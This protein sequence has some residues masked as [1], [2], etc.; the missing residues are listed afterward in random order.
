MK[1]NKTF[2]AALNCL[3][4]MLQFIREY[5]QLT[6]FRKSQIDRI[7]LASEEVL[8]NII[9]YAYPSLESG[10]ISIQCDV[11]PSREI[12]I[13]IKDQ[14]IAYNPLANFIN[15]DPSEPLEH[16]RIGGYGVFLILN[17]MD[18]IAY[19]RENLHNVLTLKKMMNSTFFE[20]E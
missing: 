6:G 20:L 18:E 2:S 14:G 16:K 12:Q 5:S 8:V 19:S 13:I 1:M 7:E 3:Y 4:E 11:I 15:I 9:N 10:I 17:V